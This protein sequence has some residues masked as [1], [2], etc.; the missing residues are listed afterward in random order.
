MAV[1][2]LLS[3]TLCASTECRILENNGTVVFSID[4]TY[5]DIGQLVCVQMAGMRARTHAR[6]HTHQPHIHT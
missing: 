4:K 1:V 3:L 5:Q 2:S 6:T